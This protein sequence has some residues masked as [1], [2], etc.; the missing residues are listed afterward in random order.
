MGMETKNAKNFG[1]RKI[2]RVSIIVLTIGLFS[3]LVG[4]LVSVNSDAYTEARKFIIQSSAV[5]RQFG[6]DISIQLDLFGYELEYAGHSG[7]ARFVCNVRGS[8]GKGEVEVTLD[9][10]DDTWRV[11]AAILN[12]S[13]I[14]LNEIRAIVAKR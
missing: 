7:T 1:L 2:G 3:Y 11:K 13:R 9:K 6:N 10:S 4:Y 14:G 8:K 12:S 5:N